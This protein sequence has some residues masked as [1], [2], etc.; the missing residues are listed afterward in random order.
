MT[1]AH[2]VL[3]QQPAALVC[4]PFTQPPA[5]RMPL[6]QKDLTS[7]TVGCA[8]T[9]NLRSRSVRPMFI[10]FENSWMLS[11]ECR[12]IM[13]T[14]TISPV[15]LRYIILAMPSDSSSARLLLLACRGG[16]GGCR[17]AGAQ[18]MGWGGV[19][20]GRVAGWLLRKE[21]SQ[22]Q[23]LPLPIRHTHTSTAPASTTLEGPTHTH[24][25]CS[26]SLTRP[27]WLPTPPSPPSPWRRPQSAP[28][29]RPR[30]G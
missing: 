4:I 15:S 20:I 6:R 27:A 5:Q 12:P 14:P 24:A 13:C 21:I 17:G 23:P 29:R 30:G 18:A 3:L 19:R 10:A 11:A 2:A 8:W 9:L 25:P 7:A 22:H 28:Q 26:R 1:P 16:Q